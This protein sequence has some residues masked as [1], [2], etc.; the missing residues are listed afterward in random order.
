M[1]ISIVVP[2]KNE[3]AT[4]SKL[5]D[6][7][8]A[9]MLAAN[10]ADY[11]VILVD[12]GSTDNSWPVMKSLTD[13]KRIRCLRLR[14]NFGKAMA[15]DCGFGQACGDVVITMDA[16]LQDDPAEIP[17]FLDQINQGFDVVSGWKKNRHDPLSKNLPSKLFNKVTA[18]VTGIKLHDFNC[19]FKAY[20]RAVL[21]NLKLYGELH[22]YVP[23]LAHDAGFKVTEVVV[24][25]RPRTHG[26]SKY[27]WERYTR[28]LLDLITVMATTR[29]LQKPGHLFGGAGLLFGAVGAVILF[30]LGVLWLVGDG[31][32]GSR[33]LFSI[34]I[35]FEILSIQLISLG[36]LAEL[37][38]RH[39]DR[40]TTASMIETL[41]GY[42][43]SENTLSQK[44]DQ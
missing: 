40:R 11:E 41:V 31:P 5:V 33:P 10:E 17:K 43:D 22:R 1:N 27:G 4:L 16:D 36:I 8:D 24:N 9:V 34:G 23:V 28:G 44:I 42:E 35:L 26:E 13:N 39:S 15:L 6:E 2:V 3:E 29:Y 25:H 21:D 7:V 18:K 38:T 12:D 32:I 19:G 37:I 14:R 30:Y 20:R